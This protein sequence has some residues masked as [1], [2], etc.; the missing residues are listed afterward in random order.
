M[1]QNNVAAGRM[2][3]VSTEQMMRRARV[4][5]ARRFVVATETG[6]LHRLRREEAGQ[7]PVRWTHPTRQPLVSEGMARRGTDE[8]QLQR[9]NQPFAHF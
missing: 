8:I 6:V 1:L 5:P 7:V 2:Q 4:S 3:I 9:L